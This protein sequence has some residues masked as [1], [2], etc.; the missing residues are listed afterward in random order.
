MNKIVSRLGHDWVNIVNIRLWL[1]LID[2]ISPKTQPWPIYFFQCKSFTSKKLAWGFSCNVHSQHLKKGGRQNRMEEKHRCHYISAPPQLPTTTTT[3][4]LNRARGGGRK[5]LRN[6]IALSF[7]LI[8]FSTSN[9]ER[10]YQPHCLAGMRVGM[11][12]C[13]E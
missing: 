8:Q 13:L 6:S 10:H 2:A 4:Q 3:S 7:K 11:G 12:L 1:S 9:L 5:N